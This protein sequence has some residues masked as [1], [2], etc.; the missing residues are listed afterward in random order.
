[1]LVDS[2]FDLKV[3]VMVEYE[4]IQNFSD[5]EFNSSVD[6]PEPLHP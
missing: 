1:M 2:P 5:F 3:G 4:M 6:D